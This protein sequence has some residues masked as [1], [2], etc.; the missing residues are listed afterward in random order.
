MSDF[1]NKVLL[2]LAVPEILWSGIA[3]FSFPLLLASP[4]LFFSILFNK[5]EFSILFLYKMTGLSLCSERST[6]HPCSD[7]GKSV[8]NNINVEKYWIIK[9]LLKYFLNK[10][11]F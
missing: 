10:I 9:N 3:R 11:I 7:D 2:F 1:C 8:T 4:S 6:D 5:P